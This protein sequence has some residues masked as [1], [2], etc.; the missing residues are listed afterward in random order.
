LS[1][2]VMSIGCGVLFSVII[3]D[4]VSQVTTIVWV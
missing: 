3:V 2:K 1:V 4:W